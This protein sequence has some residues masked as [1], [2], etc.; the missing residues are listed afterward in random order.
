[1]PRR[2]IV[3]TVVVL[4]AVATLAPTPSSAA[5][6][7]TTKASPAKTTK[8]APPPT[9]T[10]RLLPDYSNL[11]IALAIRRAAQSRGARTVSAT[12]RFLEPDLI[13]PEGTYTLKGTIDLTR[14]L[15]DVAMTIQGSPEKYLFVDDAAYQKIDPQ[16]IAEVGGS[17]VRSTP[18]SRPIPAGAILMDIAFATPGMVASVTKW[19]DKT[20]KSDRAKGVRRA[21]GTGSLDPVASY[22]S[23][24][25][26]DSSPVIETMIDKSGKI[27]A[28]KWR[29][30][31]LS[32]STSDPVEFVTTYGASSTLVVTAPD[33]D[34]VEYSD[35]VKQATPTS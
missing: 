28:V 24:D 6:K 10:D 11:P 5:T 35:A 7:T 19:T 4:T 30:E 32:E 17:W 13:A 31:P 23:P 1:M 3:S 25:D 9:A 16:S 22:L 34:V 8:K 14:R 2:S 29:L 21:S 27:T 26:Y 15:A 33:T 12:L 18:D 20:A